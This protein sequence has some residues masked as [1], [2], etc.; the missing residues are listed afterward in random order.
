MPRTRVLITLLSAST[1]AFA[2]ERQCDRLFEDLQEK[3][4]CRALVDLRDRSIADDE[5]LELVSQQVHGRSYAEVQADRKKAEEEDRKARER[6]ARELSN[7]RCGQVFATSYESD[8]CRWHQV[9]TGR[10][11]SEG[12][13][14]KSV[15][16]RIEA[17][18][19]DPALMAAFIEATKNMRTATVKEHLYMEKLEEARAEKERIETEEERARQ[20]QMAQQ[21]KEMAAH[22]AEE[23]RKMK[24][25]REKWDRAEAEW[26]RK[27][28]E[29]AK[30]EAARLNAALSGSDVGILLKGWRLGGFGS[31]LISD[32]LI[33]NNRKAAIKDF[34]VACQTFG[35][36]GTPLSLATGVIY[37][38][39]TPGERRQ[40]ELNLG[41]VHPQSAKA[42]CRLTGWK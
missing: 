16:N 18:Q 38:K 11:E 15:A 26:K 39:L 13:L 21:A 32:L 29:R 35:E 5:L 23:E 34:R 2:G 19:S 8:V 17:M 20:A 1:F 10:N 22:Q 40:F 31:I 36:S 30:A 14:R 4:T 24:A 27:E 28:R 7:D 9:L 37:S 6:V 42:S 25:Q 33:Q 41:V 3:A 12:E